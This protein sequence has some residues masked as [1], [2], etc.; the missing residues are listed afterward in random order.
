MWTRGQLNV[1]PAWEKDNTKLMVSC[2]KNSNGPDFT[3]FGII[4][5]PTTMVYEVDPFFD[6]AALKA[7]LAGDAIRASVR[8]PTPANVA[9]L[10]KQM[11]LTRKALMELVV[12]QFG[13]R[14]SNAYR[15][16]S[17]AEG[18]TIKRNAKREY[19]AI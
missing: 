4:L 2:G 10:V 5:N 11:P 14:Q 19:Q 17:N 7:E 12:E 1:S 9:L 6:L 8:K 16:I 18:H 15:I 3:P 13:C